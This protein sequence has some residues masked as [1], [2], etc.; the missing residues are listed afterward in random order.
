MKGV[1]VAAAVL[2]VV[3]LGP[4]F[5][6]TGSSGAPS[7]APYVALPNVVGMRFPAAARSLK[8]FGLTTRR[9]TRASSRPAGVVVDQSPE[10]GVD[11]HALTVVTLGVSDGSLAAGSAAPSR[12]P[13]PPPAT[14]KPVESEPVPLPNYVGMRFPA[15]ARSLKGLGLTTRREKRA[16][17][18][19]AGVIVDQSPEAGVDARTTGVVTLGVSDGSLIAGATAK[20]VKSEPIPLPNYVG[21]RFPA[22]ARALTE[23]GLPAHRQMRPSRRPAG[24]VLAQSPLPGVDARYVKA[25]TLAVSD[26]SLAQR[27]PEPAPVAIHTPTVAH[28]PVAVRTPA[29]EHTPAAARTPAARTPAPA[30]TPL[31]SASAARVP[32]SPRTP[33]PPRATARPSTRVTH[34]ASP[35]AGTLATVLVPSVVGAEQQAAASTVRRSSLRAI[36]RGAEPSSLAAGRVTRT[37]PAPGTR[38]SRG[39]LVGYWVASGANGVP[40][41]LGRSLDDAKAVLEKDGFRLG[42]VTAHASASAPVTEQAP[43][44]GVL[45]PVGSEVSV[46]IGIRGQGW[47]WWLLAAGALLVIGALG[48]SIGNGMR[49][50]RMTSRALTIHP[51]LDV[52]GPVSFDGEATR[53]GPATHIRASVE[54]GEASFEGDGEIMMREERDVGS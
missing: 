25:V 13:K 27:T 39:A 16:S 29:V 32:R 23:F 28:A 43:L 50:A 17:S 52:D 49:R 1:L 26:G 48:V 42:S 41:V 46:T 36:Y 21:M 31:R 22:A 18:R 6:Q 37:D 44:A 3:T 45:A 10:P 35:S 14:A 30:R 19:P 34:A 5:A 24:L 2:T 40:N 53:V 20:P 38:L 8:G 4:A 33:T 12:A 51:S 15:A 9:E 11:V 47:A 54:D 7:S